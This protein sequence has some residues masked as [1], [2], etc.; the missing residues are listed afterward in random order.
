LPVSLGGSWLYEER[1][2]QWQAQRKQIELECFYAERGRNIASMP[3]DELLQKAVAARV[4]EK[5][6]RRRALDVLYARRK[7]VSRKIEV[8]AIEEQVKRLTEQNTFLCNRNGILQDLMQQALEVVNERT[9]HGSLDD[10]K[11]PGRIS[12]SFPSES[13]SYSA[14]ETGRLFSSAAGSL[15]ARSQHQRHQQD[16]HDY[17]FVDYPQDAKPAAR[18]PGQISVSFPSEGFTYSASETGRLFSSAAGSLAARLQHQQHQQDQHGYASVDYPQDAKTAAQSDPSHA[19]LVQKLGILSALQE[20][21]SLERL[22]QD[23]VVAK[24]LQEKIMRDELDQEGKRQSGMICEGENRWQTELLRQGQRQEVELQRQVQAFRERELRE[25]NLLYHNQIQ[26]SARQTERDHNMQRQVNQTLHEE[27][28]Q[29][30]QLLRDGIARHE[31][32]LGRERELQLENKGLRES[33]EFDSASRAQAAKSMQLQVTSGKLDQQRAAQK[34]F[35]GQRIQEKQSPQQQGGK[36]GQ[37]QPP[38]EE[39]Q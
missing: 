36:G 16:Q 30:N 35:Q 20:Q 29:L 12:V 19:L 15:A 8:E 3:L 34:V 13:F 23:P 32:Q 21:G 31:C 37:Q 27:I 5:K 39:D 17:A 9:L 11:P 18:S 26:E 33:L 6:K 25:G 7:K 28:S 1:F 14:S 10:R 38:E 24:A 2:T 22:L 4:D